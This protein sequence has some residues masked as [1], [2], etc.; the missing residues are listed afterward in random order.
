MQSQDA[1]PTLGETI[2]SLEQYNRAWQER[3]KESERR[4]KQL[5]QDMAHWRQR[6]CFVHTSPDFSGTTYDGKVTSIQETI[7]QML[8]G[9]KS[10]VRISTRQMDMFEDKLIRLKEHDPTLSITVLSRGPNK[11]EGDRRAIAGRAFDR[12]KAAGIKLPVETDL[13]HSR[14]VIVDEREVLVSSADLDYTQMEKEFN[15]GIW[16][17]DPDVAAAATCFFDNLLQSPT[18]KGG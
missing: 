14:M 1:Q 11:A 5:E 4:V 3:L 13:L 10:S 9:A 16:T 2:R 17:S 18:I 8:R 6:I 12:M 7:Q 15:A